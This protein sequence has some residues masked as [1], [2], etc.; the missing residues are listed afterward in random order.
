MVILRSRLPTIS[1]Y[2]KSVWTPKPGHVVRSRVTIVSTLD[3]KS[4]RAHRSD[5]DQI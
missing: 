2:R 4:T 5:M 1:P 3:Q